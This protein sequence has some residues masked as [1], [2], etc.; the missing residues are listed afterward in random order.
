MTID[1]KEA[2]GLARFEHRERL[3]GCRECPDMVGS[4]VAGPPVT[5]RVFLLGQAPGLHEG[6]VGKP[7]GWTA[8]NTPFS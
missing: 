7:F 4:V 6:Q 8:G 3:L 2:P 5:S 1:E